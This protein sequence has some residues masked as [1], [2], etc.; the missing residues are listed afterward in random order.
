MLETDPKNVTALQYL[1]SLAYE[2]TTAI[3]DREGKLRQLEVARSAYEKL[4]AADPQGAEAWYSLGVIDWLEWYPRWMDALTN[5]GMKPDV[6]KPLPEPT[7]TELRSKFGY[8]IQDGIANLSRALGINPAQA[9]AMAYMNLL[10][11]ER[12]SLA[13]AAEACAAD[14]ASANLWVQRAIEAKAARNSPP[15]GLPPGAS[16][17][18]RLR[19]SPEL[20]AERLTRRVDPDYPPLAKQAR[21]QG[22]VRFNAVIGVDGHVRNLQ[23]VSGHP[24]LVSAAR[25]AL[26]QWV[27][28]PTYLNGAPVEVITTVDVNFALTDNQTTQP[29]L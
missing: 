8:L 13:D 12:A 28:R 17:S 24:V 26:E 6:E 15:G 14:I 25:H 11:R 2:E 29:G 4:T 18:P 3:S 1:A 16:Q 19:V 9:D 27:D 22:T 10:I 7:R 20:Q 21:I 23:L 5:A